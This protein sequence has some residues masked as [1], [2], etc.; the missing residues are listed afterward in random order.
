M[1]AMLV[2]PA[3]AAAE[4]VDNTGEQVAFWICAT[5]A[6]LGA[7]GLVLSRKAV[8]SALFMA[9]TMISLAILYVLN[10]APFL[11]MVQV[12]V[13]TGA[14]MMLFLFVLMIV[15]VEAADTL[16]ETIKG[17]RVWA[18]L[19]GTGF[20]VLLITGIVNGLSETSSTGLAEANAA[21][22]GNAQGLAALI[23]S[24]YLLAMQVVAALL[25]T[26]ALGALVL[27]HR[28]HI[29]PRK[30]QADLSRDRF[31][32]GEHPGVLPNPGVISGTNAIGNPALLPDGSPSIESI[33]LP[34][35]S[36][37]GLGEGSAE[38]DVEA[39]ALERGEE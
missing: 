23:F 12:I 34:L 38:G 33:P 1:T 11:G 9:L 2:I 27:A 36:H 20:A 31:R 26:A 10:S 5:L 21:Y 35:R 24:R 15:G 8:H 32:S 28:E 22:G 3:Q 19:L 37:V 39:P 25:I 6:V 18:A 13:Y 29:R 14:V 4:A 16:T 7:L 17:Q 30:R